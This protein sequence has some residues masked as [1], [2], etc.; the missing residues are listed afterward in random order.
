[1]RGGSAA[2]KRSCF[3]PVVGIRSWRALR[4][5]IPQVVLEIGNAQAAVGGELILV[6]Y[7][8]SAH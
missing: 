7:R 1:M 3:A 5:G 8:E 6:G 4:W 2:D